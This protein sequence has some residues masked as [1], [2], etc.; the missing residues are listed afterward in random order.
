TPGGCRRLP[1]H[2]RCY[3]TVTA[4]LAGAST[5]VDHE[6]VCCLNRFDAYRKLVIACEWPGSKHRAVT[7]CEHPNRRS[8]TPQSRSCSTTWHCASTSPKGA[9]TF[10]Y[11]FQVHDH[12]SDR[13]LRRSAAGLIPDLLWCSYDGAGHRPGRRSS[14]SP[15][16]PV[17]AGSVLVSRP[18]FYTPRMG[19]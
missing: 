17:A 16:Q 4:T 19:L 15:S 6:V 11:I 14:I 13:R 8:N 3:L 5:N 7:A 12:G 1:V 2:P 10:P 18:V 9:P